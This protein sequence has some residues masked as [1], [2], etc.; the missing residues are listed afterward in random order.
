[1]PVFYDGGGYRSERPAQHCQSSSSAVQQSLADRPPFAAPWQPTQP[2][3]QNKQQKNQKMPSLSAPVRPAPKNKLKTGPTGQR[4]HEKKTFT[5]TPSQHKQTHH[6][7]TK[8]KPKKVH[9]TAEKRRAATT[10][11]TQS[12]GRVTNPYKLFH[13]NHKH[14]VKYWVHVHNL[15]LE[16][17]HC[18]VR[19]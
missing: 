14:L 9:K 13:S 8:T 6:N 10:A 19:V 7:R 15:N 3:K 11:A 5:S 18:Y 2:S 16:M 17:T 12:G 4:D 1:M